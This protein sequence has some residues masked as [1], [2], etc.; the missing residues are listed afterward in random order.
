MPKETVETIVN[1]A[2]EALLALPQVIPDLSERAQNS[3]A[4]FSKHALHGVLKELEQRI[5]YGDPTKRSV[6]QLVSDYHRAKNGWAKW[7]IAK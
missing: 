6:K 1:E 4:A 3:K 5:Q 2:R 7:Q